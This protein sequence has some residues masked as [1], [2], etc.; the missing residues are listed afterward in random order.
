MTV[1]YITN[2]DIKLIEE[3]DEEVNAFSVF[4]CSIVQMYRQHSWSRVRQTIEISY[5]GLDSFTAIL[6]LDTGNL[7]VKLRTELFRKEQECGTDNFSKGLFSRRR[8][9]RRSL[10]RGQLLCQR[11]VSSEGDRKRVGC[12]SDGLCQRNKRDYEWEWVGF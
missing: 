6:A 3:I 7:S 4:E 12:T 1:E 9:R 8:G 11:R 2:P 10:V 5:E